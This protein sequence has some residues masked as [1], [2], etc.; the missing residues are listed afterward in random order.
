MKRRYVAL[1]AAVC[2]ASMAFPGGPASAGPAA[3]S[4]QTQVRPAENGEPPY[5]KAS[6]LRWAGRDWY[7]R[8]SAWNDGGPMRTDEWSKDNAS[9]SGNDLV[10]K[11]N[12]NRGK[13]LMTGSEIV[14]ADAVGY[15]DY[16][17][18][19]TSNTREFDEHSVFGAFTYDWGS[20]ATKGNSEV[21]LIETSRWHE[22]DNKMRAKFTYYRDSDSKS[23][24]ISPY[25]MWNGNRTSLLREGSRTENVPA[26]TATTRMHLNAWCSWPQTGNKDDDD[27]LLHRE[28]KP[29]TVKVH[30]FD[31]TPNRAADPREN[32]GSGW[33]RL[34]S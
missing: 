20:N 11:L 14:S 6:K 22:K 4:A 33:H 2:A 5:G 30:G 32:S 9:V 21:D 8:D 16:T 13:R 18:S 3:G 27:R 34:S 15:G 17:L 26:P 24:E 1:A 23:F 28:T 31:Y 19:F 10:L 25:A 12:Y 7:V 29:I